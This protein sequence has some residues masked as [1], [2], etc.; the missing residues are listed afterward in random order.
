MC[1]VEVIKAYGNYK[2]GDEISRMHPT[3]AE[4]IKRSGFV[5]ITVKESKVGSKDTDFYRVR[6]K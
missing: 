6:K 2:V 4:S 5:K 1:K 3:T